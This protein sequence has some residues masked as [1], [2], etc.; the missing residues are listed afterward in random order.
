[1][2]VQIFAPIS[3][4]GSPTSQAD[5]LTK[6]ALEF[7]VLLHRTFNETRKELLSNRKKLQAEID[8]GADLHFSNDSRIT[9]SVWQGASPA[10][11]L[12]DRRTEITG[13]PERKMIVNALNT[14]VKTYMADFEDSTSPKWSNLLNGQVNLYDAIRNQVDF[15]DSNTGK[16]YKVDRSPERHIPT[17]LVRPRGW[18]MVEKHL[19][20]DGEPCS[21]SIFDFGLYFYHNAKELIAKGHGPYF[22]LPKMEHHLEAKLWNDIFN[23]SQDILKIKRGTVRATVLIETLPAAYQMEEILYQLRDHSSGLNCG[24]WDYIFS[25]IKTFKNRPDKVLPDRGLVTMTVPF[26]LAYC[27]RLIEICHKRGV[28]AMGGMAAQIPIKDDPEANQ[29][30]M[31][32]V[33]K[34]KLREVTMHYDGTWVAHPALATIAN[35][36]FDKYMPTPNQIYFTTVADVSELDLSNTTV[37]GGSVTLDGIRQNIYIALCYIESWL[38]GVGCVPINYLMEDA[39]TA[40]V[41]RLQL[42]SWVTNGVVLDDAKVNIT[43]ELMESILNEETAKLVQ[44]HGEGNKFQMAANALLPEIRGDSISD[45]LTTMIYDNVVE[46][47]KSVNLESL[48]P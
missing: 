21:A 27:K 45:F 14:P 41:S 19:L 9:D 47:G 29:V 3:F 8:A 37:V 25:T 2:T 38:R 36:I 31:D 43:P 11:G 7:V 34:D 24:R 42:Y 22:Y 17:I 1:M 48:K 5:I 44:S 16:A 33:T 28:H 4:E 40:E 13:P 46:I 23:V 6:S 15:V 12:I 35:S 26:M 32:K 10:P 18:H 30:A 39:A 20:I